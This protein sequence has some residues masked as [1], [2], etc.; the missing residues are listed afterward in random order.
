MMESLQ[1]EQSYQIQIR[2][3]REEKEELERMMQM[4]RS[5]ALMRANKIES[6]NQEIV[7]LNAQLQQAYE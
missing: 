3:L 4:Y 5:Q 1:R 7:L 6:M 2:I